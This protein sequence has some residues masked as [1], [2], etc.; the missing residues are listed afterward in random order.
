MP[1]TRVEMSGRVASVLLDMARSAHPLEMLVLLRG[2]KQ[3]DAVVVEDLLFAPLSQHSELSVYFRMNLMPMDFSV[4]G[5]AHSHPSGAGEPSLED[6]HNFVGKVMLILT[7]PY[8]GPEDIHAYDGEGRPLR[9][10]VR[11]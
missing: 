4:V 3:A 5:L 8:E 2:R 6:L 7:P 9:V 11:G 10:E 1:L